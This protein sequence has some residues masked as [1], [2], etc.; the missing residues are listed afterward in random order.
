MLTH[1]P[2]KIPPLSAKN[3][4]DSSPRRLRL[5]WFSNTTR[6]QAKKMSG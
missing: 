1:T 6:V 2:K 5:G 4:L 3:P